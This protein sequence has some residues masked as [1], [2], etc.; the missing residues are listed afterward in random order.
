[1][2]VRCSSSSQKH[3]GSHNTFLG[4]QTGDG[5]HHLMMSRVLASLPFLSLTRLSAWA[6]SCVGPPPPSQSDVC[7]GQPS[8]TSSFHLLS[9]F[10]LSL[11]LPS[12]HS[13]LFLRQT[14]IHTGW[15]TGLDGGNRFAVA[16][17]EGK[18]R[19][20]FLGVYH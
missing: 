5:S 17:P 4:R 19:R 13:P 18:R 14:S 11:Q 1:M 15:K 8:F 7:T 3:A 10:L 20:L 9:P 6:H 16:T 2:T 12:F